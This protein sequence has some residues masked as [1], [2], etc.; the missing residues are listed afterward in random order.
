MK[1]LRVIGVPE[2][3]NLPW[4]LAIEKGLF[5]EEGIILEWTDVPEGTGKMSKMLRENEADLAIILTEGIVRSIVEGNPSK[6]I[7]NYI[8]TPLLWGIHVGA[9]SPYYK[10][11]DLDGKVSAISRI[12]SGSHLMSFV[13]AKKQGWDIRNINLNIINTLDGA[14]KSITSNESDYFLWEQ[15]TTKPLVDSGIFRFLGNCPT[16]WPCFVIAASENALINKREEVKAVL[17]CINSFTR[18]FKSIPGIDMT[19]ANR[20]KQDLADI[21]S[22]LQITEWSQDPIQTAT[23]IEVQDTLEELNL[24]SHKLKP[25]LLFTNL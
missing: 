4:H 5:H 12:G 24:I 2:H 9:E 6:I 25:E 1:T 21:R 23:L 15:F 11:K 10:L 18:E 7:Q 19:L 17:K 13:N 20:Y 8:A 3:F 22:W 16:P 14:I